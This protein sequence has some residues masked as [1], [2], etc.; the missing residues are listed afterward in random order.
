M[1][2][3]PRLLVSAGEPSGDLHAAP[4]VEALRA[5]WP[6][7]VVDA[8][9]GPRLAAA[10]A[11]VRWRM[12]DYAAFGLAEVV[13]SLPRHAR[14]LRE[15]RRALTRGDWDLVVLLDYPGFHLRVAEAARAAGVPV[16]Y[17]IAPQLWAWRPERARRFAGAVDR[18][19]V[20]LPFEA[21]FFGRLGV[22]ATYVGHPLL[23][24]ELWPD[25]AEARRRLGIGAGDRVLALLPGSRGGEVRRLWPALREAAFRLRREGRCDRVLVASTGAGTYPGADGFTLVPGDSRLVMAAADAALAKSGTTTLEC[26]LAGTPMVV[27]YAVHPVTWLIARRL[28]TVPYVSLVN[29]VAER[30]VVPELLQGEVTP[31]RLVAEATPLLQPGS[32]AHAAQLRGFAEVRNRLGG[33]GA[34]VRVAGLAGELLGR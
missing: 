2:G 11:R 21:A 1:P 27:A 12:E 20:I 29:L 32:T 22:A 5:R 7:A 19:A 6:D 23:D 17:Y 3:G 33:P 31:D 15:W 26:A 10:G 13:A 25:R 34:A 16:L 28:V 24:G 18:L 8:L 9:G 14:L 4:V 30:P